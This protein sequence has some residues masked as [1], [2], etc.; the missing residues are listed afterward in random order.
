MDILEVH[1]SRCRSAVVC[2]SVQVPYLTRPVSAPSPPY[3]QAL[4]GRTFKS[5][6]GSDWDGRFS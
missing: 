4:G 1:A 2:K 5:K 3:A 6:Q